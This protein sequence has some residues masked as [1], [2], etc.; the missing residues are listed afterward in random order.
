MGVQTLSVAPGVQLTLERFTPDEKARFDNDFEAFG[1]FYT[2]YSSGAQG[3]A[4]RDIFNKYKEQFFLFAQ[5]AKNDI[6]ASGV[7]QGINAT[8]GF[9]MQAIRPD[10]LVPTAQDRTYKAALSGLTAYDWYGLYHNAAIG[11]AYNTTSLYLRKE[12]AVAIA[13]FVELANP[14]ADA[15]RFEINGKQ[16]PVWRMEEALKAGDLRIYEAPQVI[17]LAP[18]KQYRS[19]FKTNMAAG[20]MNLAPIG[21]AYVSADYMRTTEPTAPSTSAP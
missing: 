10:Y 2:K 16:L 7:F 13:G 11:G 14:I 17:Y 12:L 4:I 15:V 6:E 3:H 8:N 20:N 9:G 1:N 19:E 5:A 21:V 18:R